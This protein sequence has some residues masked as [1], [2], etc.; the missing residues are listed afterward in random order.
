MS[1][2]AEVS[3]SVCQIC[4]STSSGRSFCESCVNNKIKRACHIT[5]ARLSSTSGNRSFKRGSL[6]GVPHAVFVSGSAY[7]SQ[8]SEGLVE[9]YSPRVRD[10]ESSNGPCKIGEASPIT[11]APPHT[12]FSIDNKHGEN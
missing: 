7:F 5:P 6:P 4:S 1:D 3:S 10:S 2:M 11:N 9:A 8:D 12:L